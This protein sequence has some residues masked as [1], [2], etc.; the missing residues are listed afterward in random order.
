[1]DKSVVIIQKTKVSSFPPLMALMEYFH[2]NGIHIT[3]ICGNEFDSFMPFLQKN[4]EKVIML[5][6]EDARPN[7]FSKLTTWV[8]I[9]NKIWKA[10]KENNLINKTFYIPTADT[11]LAM[12]PK[13]KRLKYI[14]NLYELYDEAP[15]YL[16]HLKQYAKPAALITCPDETRA[17]IFRVWWGL[18]KTPVVIPNKPLERLNV[19]NNISD[20]VEQIKIQ[21]GDRKIIHYQGLITPDRGL[22]PICKAVGGMAD[23]VLILM[24]RKTEYLEQLLK[25]S[26]NIIYVPFI[27]PP[28]H[29][30]MTKLAYIGVLSYDH[31]CLTNIFC[32]PN[33]IWEY[34][35]LGVP[36]L[37]NDIPGLFNVINVNNLGRCVDYDDEERVKDAIIDIEKNHEVYSSNSWS[38]FDSFNMDEAYKKVIDVI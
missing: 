37:G 8:K 24:G 20:V 30:H 12:G 5:D 4:C 15:I 9:H 25:I 3:L 1:M 19:E 10:I 29:L 14:F 13:T 6:V 7:V 27:A 32:A 18:D 31:S 28:Y 2:T 11:I 35:S 22:E 21:V 38:Y 23:Y 34:S 26:E 17:H 33:K 36:M 16:R